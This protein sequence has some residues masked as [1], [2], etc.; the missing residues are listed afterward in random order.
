MGYKRDVI[1]GVSWIAVLRFFT[2]ATAFF[3][4]IILARVLVPSQFGAYGV[5]MLVVGF[6]EVMTETGVNVF[7][8]QEKD[9][10]AH[11]NSAWIVSIVRGII[12]ALVIVL[13]TP[14]IVNFFHSPESTP[15]LY[16][17]SIV[18]LLRGFINPSIVKLQ[19]NLNFNLEF[20]YKFFIFLVDSIVA[21][22][23]TLIT[24]NPIGI[25]IGMI[26]GVLFEVLLSYRIAKPTPLLQF[27]SLY[28]KKIV[29]RGKWVT[30]SGI[31]NYLFHN[32][33]NIVVG[34]I[35]GTAPLG[36][37]QIAYSLSILPISEMADVFSRVTF[38]VYA[39]TAGDKKR[40]RIAF[41]KTQLVITAL[42][43][44]FGIVLFLFPK[45]I[46]HFVLGEKWL[47]AVVVLPILGVFAVIR[48]IS[49]SASALFLAVG[50]Q[51]YVTVATFVSMVGL[52]VPI[53]P[54]V[55]RYGLWGAALSALIGSLVAMPVFLYY[56]LK[57]LKTNDEKH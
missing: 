33:D 21:I 27:N 38:P 23:F 24:H 37:Y 22:A 55:M 43:V 46:V 25:V 53:V 30:A 34:R 56:T 19:K 13:S 11:I 7:L 54:M 57:V 35:L 42:A 1:R 16:T 3:K 47:G 10:D 15:L 17:I 29:R 51:E 18:P 14:L 44:P 45:E 36:A 4:T 39:K 12:I 20:R 48:T 49:G 6:L 41:V 32:A 40:L 5:A 2:R 26:V 52:I 31:F 9:T 50:K 28:I 8:I